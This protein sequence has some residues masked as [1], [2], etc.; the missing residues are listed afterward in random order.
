MNTLG[1]VL[2]VLGFFV[3]AS[4]SQAALREAMDKTVK[5][6]VR[7]VTQLS[8]GHA[9]SPSLQRTA[10]TVIGERLIPEEYKAVPGSGGTFFVKDN[11]K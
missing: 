3:A 4:K 7:V 9:P 10:P 1:K 6:G 5:T 8:K 2:I 11:K